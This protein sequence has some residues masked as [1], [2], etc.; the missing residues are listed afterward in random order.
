M[1]D[2]MRWVRV[3]L[4][5]CTSGSVACGGQTPASP[6]APSPPAT[7]PAPTPEGFSY[8]ID[9]GIPDA[10]QGAIRDGL[11]LGQ[12]FFRLAFGKP[13][14]GN[15]LITISAAQGR[16]PAFAGSD[17]ITFN[18][19]HSVWQSTGVISK[20]KIAVHE[21]FHVFQN[22]NGFISNPTWFIEGG[23][24]YVG[25]QGIASAGLL[26]YAVAKG[27]QVFSLLHSS[28]PV[29]KLRD[30][31]IPSNRGY[32]LAFLAID[33]MTRGNMATFGSIINQPPAAWDAKMTAVIGLSADQFYD[34]FEAER[35]T[36]RSAPNSE[37]PR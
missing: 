10:D 36:F 5:V 30:G 12:T 33:Y 26:D 7:I 23:A 21:L 27:C 9:P 13:A 20:K 15:I 29:P 28:D 11:D 18:T 6:S 16:E 35:Q 19:G 22:R 34:G 3:I 1:N 8:Q 31:G 37:C 17:M 25:Y 24:E 32:W 14:Q 2:A 4:L